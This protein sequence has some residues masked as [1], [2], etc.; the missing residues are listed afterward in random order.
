MMTVKKKNK[1][2]IHFVSREAMDINVL[3][4]K[5]LFTFLKKDLSKNF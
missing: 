5:T 4:K 3:G 2:I 1:K